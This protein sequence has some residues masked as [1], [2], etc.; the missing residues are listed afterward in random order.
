MVYR[1]IFCKPIAKPVTP[2]FRS[3]IV[4]DL[5][6][7]RN[8]PACKNPLKFLKFFVNLEHMKENETLECIMHKLKAKCIKLN[9]HLCYKP[10]CLKQN[11][12]FE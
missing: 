11:R 5:E 1:R 9:L 8:D 10:I 2:V 12:Y 3:R 6:E 7:G 4:E